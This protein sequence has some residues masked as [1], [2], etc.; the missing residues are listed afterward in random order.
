MCCVMF[1]FMLTSFSRMKYD[2]IM[3]MA[4]NAGV[5]LDGLVP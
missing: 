2:N 5:W 1:M 3:H 4:T